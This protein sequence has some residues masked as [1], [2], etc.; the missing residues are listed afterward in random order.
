MAK[1]SACIVAW[2]GEK[3]I[4]GCLESLKGV[5]DEIVVVH[6][7]PC[8]DGTIRIC[9]E[10]TSKVF[11]RPYVGEAEP[12][13]PF[14]FA[15]AS[16]EW[17]LWIDQDERLTPQLRSAIPKMI[18]RDDINA[19]SF[20]WPVKYANANLT[21]GFFSNVHKTVLFRKSA[22]DNFRGLPNEILKV[23]G[24]AIR[25]NYR[26]IHNQEGER[27]T[28]RVFF[29]RT[30]RIVR[31]HADQLLKKRLAA[32]IAP[33]YFIK[34][35]L[36]FFLYCGYYYIFHAT[37]FTKADRSIALQLALYNFFLY[38]NVFLA[39]TGLRKHAPGR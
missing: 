29:R 7:G 35:F 11:T 21:K 13:R 26:M 27:N 5:V 20:V 32:R 37:L 4:R 30:L 17:I 14:T 33:W 3:Q 22:I 16:G 34:A 15:K 38:W 10:Y 28:L 25:T 18:E 2:N 31:I 9:R 23:K 8:I 36:W 6:D 24:K 12:H 1:L 19:Y 39:K